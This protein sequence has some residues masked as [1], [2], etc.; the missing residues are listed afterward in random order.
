MLKHDLCLGKITAPWA[1]RIIASVVVRLLLDC[2]AWQRGLHDSLLP[3][4]AAGCPLCPCRLQL[5]ERQIDARLAC[6]RVT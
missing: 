2:T 1:F 5:S 3:T 4:S 6:Y